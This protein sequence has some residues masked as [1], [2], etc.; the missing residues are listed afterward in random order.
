MVPEKNMRLDL[1]WPFAKAVCTLPYPTLLS[2]IH[3]AALEAS[4]YEARLLQ[5]I[6]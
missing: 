5:R 2:L 1:E 6:R 3:T 4:G